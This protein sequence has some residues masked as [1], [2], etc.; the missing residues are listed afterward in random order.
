MPLATILNAKTFRFLF[1]N[2]NLKQ[3]A[4]GLR[5]GVSTSVAGLYYVGLYG[6][7]SFASATIPGVGA[8]ARYVVGKL[9]AKLKKMDQ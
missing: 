6:Q 1:W 3:L 4:P 5:G 9:K 8:D 2:P 7:R